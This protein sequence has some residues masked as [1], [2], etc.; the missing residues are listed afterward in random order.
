MQEYKISADKLKELQHLIYMG[1][2]LDEINTYMGFAEIK[3][4]HFE[5]Y[6]KKETIIIDSI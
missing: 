2:E 3:L 5:D 6:D 4:V 1:Y